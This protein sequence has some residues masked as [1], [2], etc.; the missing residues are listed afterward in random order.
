M[1][2]TAFRLKESR[3]AA[4][5]WEKYFI[6]TP[7]VYRFFRSYTCLANPLFLLVGSPIRPKCQR[8]EVFSHH[9]NVKAVAYEKK[10]TKKEHWLHFS[11]FYIITFPSQTRMAPQIEQH[12]VWVM[13]DVSR[14]HITA[15]NSTTTQASIISTFSVWYHRTSVH[16]DDCALAFDDL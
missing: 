12:T 4:A 15:S 13:K 3:T 16:I 11:R 14:L 1:P 9:V 7:F 6:M 10:H 8:L 5:G 2:F